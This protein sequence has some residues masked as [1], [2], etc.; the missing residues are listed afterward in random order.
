MGGEV[1]R[2]SA[3]GQGS[4]FHFTI[5]LPPA[6][7]ELKAQ[8]APEQ[9]EVVRLSPGSRV[10]VLVVDDNANN[11]DVLSQLL[12]GIGCRVRRAESAMEAFDRVQEE[13]P[14]LIFM[15]IRMPGMNGADATR[16]IIAEHGKDAIKVVAITAS[17]LEH[18]RAGH[19]AAGFHT[20]LSKPF[21]FA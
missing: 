13:R 6:R 15:D 7:G 2:Q 11:R 19:M 12:A 1:K 5:P 8:D 14:D 17:V 21:R 20:F 16:R 10:N 4:R 9:R 3:L 18:E